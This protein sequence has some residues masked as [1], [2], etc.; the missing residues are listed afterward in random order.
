MGN[1]TH[2]KFENPE[3]PGAGEYAAKCLKEGVEMALDGFSVF[4]AL[5]V[6]GQEKLTFYTVSGIV[7]NVLAVGLRF[8]TEFMDVAPEAVRW[9]RRWR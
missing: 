5:V 4:W 8:V 2:L 3:I 9:F 1:A 7:A 6:V